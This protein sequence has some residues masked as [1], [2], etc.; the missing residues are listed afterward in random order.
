MNYEV[1]YSDWWEE[2]LVPG[3]QELLILPFQS[4]QG[5]PPPP[6]AVSFHQCAD[7]PSKTQGGPSADIQS[8]LRAPSSVNSGFSALSSQLRETTLF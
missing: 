2:E 8:S 1:L 5:V 4:F 6:L 7:Q 3:L